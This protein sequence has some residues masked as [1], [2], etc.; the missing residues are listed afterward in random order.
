MRLSTPNLRI[1][2]QCVLRCCVLMV[3]WYHDQIDLSM[4]QIAQTRMSLFMQYG[5]HANGQ[6]V[7]LAWWTNASFI[8]FHIKLICI[9]WVRLQGQRHNPH[10][11][12]SPNTC[13]QIEWSDSILLTHTRLLRFTET[14]REE[15]HPTPTV[16]YTHFPKFWGSTNI[17][18]STLAKLIHYTSINSVFYIIPGMPRSVPMTRSYII[19]HIYIRKIR[20]TLSLSLVVI[21]YHIFIIHVNRKFNKIFIQVLTQPP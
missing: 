19:M 9:V 8:S 16:L 3:Q 17:A 14:L 5:N 6:P 13:F 18:P 11:G 10:P 12:I 21:L 7:A 15:Y 20:S 1:Y 4:V 2:W